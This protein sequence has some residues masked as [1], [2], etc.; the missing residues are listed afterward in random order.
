MVQPEHGSMTLKDLFIG[1]DGEIEDPENK[2]VVKE[3]LEA[4]E[5]PVKIN[6]ELAPSSDKC[7]IKASSQISC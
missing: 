6:I 1:C 5:G 2:F 4:A 3:D 7:E